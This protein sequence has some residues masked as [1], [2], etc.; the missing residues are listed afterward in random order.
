VACAPIPP[1]IFHGYKMTVNNILFQQC[2][3]IEFVIKEKSSAANI[4]D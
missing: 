1:S 2:V 4:F 3:V